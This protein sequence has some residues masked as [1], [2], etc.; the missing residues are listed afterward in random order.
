MIKITNKKSIKPTV[1]V[2]DIRVGEVF[3]RGNYHGVYIKGYETDDCCDYC[4][5]WSLGSN[6]NVHVSYK[7]LVDNHYKNAELILS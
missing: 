3:T 7:E 1:T 6:R 4:N 5:C 2:D